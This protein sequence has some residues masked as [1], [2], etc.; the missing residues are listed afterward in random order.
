MT[1]ATYSTVDSVR[2]GKGNDLS[3]NLRGIGVFSMDDI[4]EVA[5]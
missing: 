2:F 4:I 1:T 3:M 5:P